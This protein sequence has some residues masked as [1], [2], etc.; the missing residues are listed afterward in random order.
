MHGPRQGFAR[1]PARLRARRARGA[2]ARTV[3]AVAAS[4]RWQPA[5]GVQSAEARCAGA[6]STRRPHRACVRS[7]PTAQWRRGARRTRRRQW[8]W[9][10]ARWCYD[11]GFDPSSFISHTS[12]P[13]SRR[14]VSPREPGP[15]VTSAAS[16]GANQTAGGAMQRVRRRTRMCRRLSRVTR[17]CAPSRSPVLHPL[18]F[19]RALNVQ[20]NGRRQF[21]PKLAPSRSMEEPRLERSV[22]GLLDAYGR[23]AAQSSSGRRRSHLAMSSPG[24]MP[25]PASDGAPPL[26]AARTCRAALTDAL[27]SPV[28]RAGAEG[29]NEDEASLLRAC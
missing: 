27:H 26:R 29:Q 18:R 1:A 17:R 22:S 21:G 3:H 20:C 7:A 15:S 14:P 10:A 2:T 28:R 12:R 4:S 13:S 19:I 25:C 5:R 23:E 11:D 16:R 24:G 8:W 6:T 9:T